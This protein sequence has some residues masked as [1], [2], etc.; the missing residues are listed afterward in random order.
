MPVYKDKE[1][2]TWYFDFRKKVDGIVY[3]RKKRGFQSK[4][5]ALLAEQ[6]EIENLGKEK[7]QKA[8]LK[9]T[10]DDLA[11]LF[12]QYQET[13]LK[14]TTLDLVK[15]LYSKHIAPKLGKI[16]VLEL[17]PHNL[18]TWKKEFIELNYTESFYNKV[19]TVFRQ[20][21][22]FG[23]NKDYIEK[24]ELLDELEKVRLNQIVPERQVLTLD[25]IQKFLDSFVKEE[26]KEYEY[27]LYFYAFANTGMRPNEFR[28][29]QVRDIQGDYLVVN[30]SITSKLK[31]GDIIQTPKTK[32]SVRKVLMPH[33]IIV[34]LKEHTK[35]YNQTDFIFGKKRA[36]RETNLNRSLKLHLK[37]AGVPNIVLYGFRHSLATNL[38]KAGVPIKVVAQR[39]GHKN[40][41]TTMNVYWHLFQDDEQQVI[42][43][44]K[45]QK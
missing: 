9:L 14:T 32:T 30:K 12:F 41:S 43:I 26:P 34:L 35:G 3:T 33:E 5:E 21:I 1:R 13:K 15:R 23:I 36:F 45:A 22:Q 29:L 31:G 10:L 6:K 28:C 42:N 18:Y 40:A 8:D 11:A 19:I 16:L 20:I 25:E 24:K 39:L 38:I 2:G 4:T 37:A 17:K 44:L 27:W 7:E